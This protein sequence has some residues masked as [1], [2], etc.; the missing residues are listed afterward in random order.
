MTIRLQSP[1]FGKSKKALEEALNSGQTV[2][3]DDPSPFG[4]RAFRASER[5]VG[6][7]FACVMDPQ[8]R[9]RF[10]TIERRS[11]GWKVR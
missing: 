1:Q 8:T 3:F 6:T 2:W 5:L 7:K 10:A 4:D 11:G 9:M